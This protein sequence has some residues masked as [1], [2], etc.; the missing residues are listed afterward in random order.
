MSKKEKLVE[1]LGVHLEN[2]EQIAPLAARILSKLILTGRRGITFEDLVCDLCASKSTISSHLTNL[3]ATQRVTYFTKPG[4]RKKYFILSPD[5]MI[6]SM[7]EM[8]QN[9]ELESVLH[10]EV[11][12]YKEEINSSL[13]ENSDEKFELDFHKDYISFLEQASASIKKLREKLAEKE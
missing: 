11:M 4:D 13:P 9:W 12:V 5:A 3:Q 10:R 7:T 8:L 1:R 2:K 6:K